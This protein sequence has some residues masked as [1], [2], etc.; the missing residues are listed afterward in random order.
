MY[1]GDKIAKSSS[2]THVDERGG[3]EKEKKKEKKG[4]RPT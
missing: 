3:K 1:L 2:Y 4:K